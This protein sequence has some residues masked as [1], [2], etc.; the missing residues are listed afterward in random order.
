[1]AEFIPVAVMGAKE[2]IDQRQRNQ[3]AK[4]QGQQRLA[5]AQA[6]TDALLRGQAQ[7]DAARAERLKRQVAAQRASRAA[8]GISGDGSGSAVLA[9]LADDADA[10]T[11]AAHENV[12]ANVT[13]I[14]NSLGLAQRI[15]L[16]QAQ[17]RDW[18]ALTANT[19]RALGFGRSLL[20]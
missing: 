11:A 13:A 14:H 1:M 19:T 4:A 16:L 15:D 5:S 12:R 7:T 18:R 6:Q 10:E 3:Q 8:S 17:Q 20:D 2:I 9:G